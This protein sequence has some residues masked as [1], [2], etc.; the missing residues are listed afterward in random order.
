MNPRQVLEDLAT[1]GVEDVRPVT[2]DEDPRGVVVVV[3]VAAD[4]V[5]A[6]DDEHAVT[7]RRQAL[8]GD[9]AG[10]PCTDDEVVEGTRAGRRGPRRGREHALDLGLHGLPRPV[11]R[12]LA[13]D[14]LDGR[15]VDAVG[16]RGL[17]RVHEAR[18]VVADQHEPTL[19]VRLDDVGDGRRDHGL[20]RGQVLE[21]LRRADEARRLVERERHQRDIPPGDVRRQVRVLLRAEVVQVRALRKRLRVDLR[22]RTDDHDVPVGPRVGEV[23]EKH[24]VHP[25]VDDAEEPEARMRDRRLVG[26]LVEGA[27]RRAE[28][29]GVDARREHVHV[30]VP[31]R[32]RAVEA[33][34]AREDDVRAPQ[35]L[36][37]ALD[38]LG[39]RVRE[40]LQLVHAV[41]DDCAR[42][43][44]DGERRRH[45]RVV[46]EHV[47]VHLAADEQLVEERLLHRVDLVA[48]ETFRDPRHGDG[49]TRRRLAQLEPELAGHR[50]LEE[51]DAALT[52]PAAHQMLRALPNEVPPKV[53]QDDHVIRHGTPPQTGAGSRPWIMPFK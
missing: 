3:R 42:L 6:V 43:E 5:A 1:V 17:D 22:H 14:R 20:A 27:T 29:V 46:P 2:V 49:D 10:E 18:G 31:L 11:P 36:G 53:G 26:R 15:L 8:G 4:V 38:E 37:L 24:G 21:S 28:V 34:A 33:H 30:V 7:E 41:P 12:R 50:L 13:E 23:G 32:L 39:G 16:Q 48:P 45:R 47:V 19:A 51:E 25:L 9:R 40:R 52:R 35:K 44:V